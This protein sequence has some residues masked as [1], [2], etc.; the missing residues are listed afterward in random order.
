VTVREIQV[1]RP[2]AHPHQ[3]Q[4]DML[5]MALLIFGVAGL[6]LSAV[7]VATMLNG[8][9]AQQIPQ[10]GIMKAVGARSSQVLHLYLLMTLVVAETATA[11][12]FVPGILISRAWAPAVLTG[13]LG[14]D[15]ASLAAPWWMYAVVIASGICVPLLL[16]LVPLVKTSRT[17]VRAALDHRGVDYQGANATRFD[18]GLARLRG[19]DRTVLLAFRNIFRRRARF[20]LSAGLLASAGTLFVAG[21]STIGSVQAMLERAKH[22]RHWDVEIQLTNAN[23][24]SA[25]TMTNLVAQ[26]PHVTHVE[27]WTTLQ[28]S[29]AQPGQINVTR[30][31]PDQGH[32]SM[33]VTVIPPGGS[34]LMPP[35]RLLE[36][37]WLRPGETGAVVISQSVRADSLPDIRSGDTVQLSIGGRPT[38][39]RVVGVS[40]A[41]FAG[42][43]NLVTAEGFAQAGGANR[44]SMLRVVTDSHDDQ[45][46]TAVA[47]AAERVLTEASIPVR[48]SASVSR[49]E[50]AGTGHMLPIVV[51]FLAIA[52]AMGVV[53]CVGL[54]STMSTNV[55]ERTREFGVMHAIGAS[56][57][58]VRRMVISEGIFVALASCV[59]GAIPAVLLTAA[60][61]TGLGRL[62]LYG[63]L[64]FR[65]SVPATVIWI[66]AVVLGAV[67]ATLPPASRASRLSVR[68]A[69]AYL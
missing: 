39:W 49:F 15:A 55:L 50:A 3:W 42:P 53:G 48:S 62:F 1:P 31:Y 60:M 59:V 58:A 67:L 41:L 21:M 69:L 40:E 52:I 2:Y 61:S 23:R 66:A 17:T 36:G 32:G 27:A 26:I 25:T 4:L 35:P 14:M 46:R 38:R 56:A 34:A 8:L 51:I 65:V 63:A 64:P 20:L 43:G 33:G 57:G 30:T 24:A 13:L 16:A 44:S 18:A 12:A 54:A 68:E 11:L 47:H 45:T 5:L 10:I 28:T 9:F 6:L 29:I 7:L 37:R 22:Q 19:L